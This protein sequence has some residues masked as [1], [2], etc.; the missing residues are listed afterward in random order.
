MSTITTTPIDLGKGGFADLGIVSNDY[1]LAGSAAIDYQTLTVQIAQTRAHALEKEITPLATKMEAR[2]DELALLGE[3][4][5]IFTEASQRF[6]SDAEGS[7]KTTF[8]LDAE[9]Y[10]Y[11]VDQDLISTGITY[12]AT[13]GKMTATKSALAGA[14]EAVKTRMD[15]LNNDAQRDMTR[16]ESLVARR[17]EAFEAASKFLNNIS[18]SRDTV[19][20]GITR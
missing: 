9:I 15:G 13:T 4:L 20:K 5:S 12:N 7:D 10:A 18:G 8:T 11:L 14:N 6:P 2:N 3:T 1:S 16:L 17:D 19:L